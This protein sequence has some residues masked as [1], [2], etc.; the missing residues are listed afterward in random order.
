MAP[1]KHRQ[2]ENMNLVS[3]LLNTNLDRMSSSNGAG[4]AGSSSVRYS[5]TSVEFSKVLHSKIS[6]D[7]V[8]RTSEFQLDVRQV[9]MSAR[10]T[11][12]APRATELRDRSQTRDS[13]SSGQSDSSKQSFQAMF[14]QPGNQELLRQAQPTESERS[15]Q[16]NNGNSSNNGSGSSDTSAA[17]KEVL[18]DQY[19]ADQGESVEESLS[20]SDREIIRKV[21][22]GNFELSSEKDVKE[23]KKL[24]EKLSEK[25]TG[26]AKEK[27]IKLL[28]KLLG[29]NG[30]LQ[31]LIEKDQSAGET[32]KELT[33]LQEILKKSQDLFK[34]LSEQVNQSVVDQLKQGFEKLKDGD[35][36]DSKLNK[37][38]KQIKQ[39]LSKESENQSSVFQKTLKE[40]TKQVQSLIEQFRKQSGEA[41]SKKQSES[42]KS[43]VEQLNKSFGKLTGSGE[44]G[45]SV[46]SET[47]KQYQQA[48]KVA[49]NQLKNSSLKENLAKHLREFRQQNRSD[50]AKQ[51]A[52]AKDESGSTEKNSSKNSQSKNSDGKTN[53]S[54]SQPSQSSSGN[55][56]EKQQ[57]ASESGK[58]TSKQSSQGTEGRT[59]NSSQKAKSQS[60][61]TQSA[62]EAASEKSGSAESS[63]NKYD[64]SKKS[65][66]TSTKGEDAEKSRSKEQTVKA[67]TKS[68]AANKQD[69]ES[70]E[71]KSSENKSSDEKSKTQKS[72]STSTAGQS[73]DR[74]STGG[75]KKSRMA[76]TPQE[77]LKAEQVNRNRSGGGQTV[78]PQPSTQPDQVQQ[79]TRDFREA[80][81]EQVVDKS[82]KASEASK[83]VSE[84][85]AEKSGKEN[86]SSQKHVGKMAQYES[87][88]AKSVSSTDGSGA[89]FSNNGNQQQA[90]QG[91]ASVR[92]S[93][94]RGS[95]F[96][97][98]MR[99]ARKVIKQMV[100]KAQTM[101]ED[102]KQTMKLQLQPPELG[103][104]RMSI[105]L[106]GDRAKAKVHVE[107]G[108]VKNLLDD[109]MAQL[110][111]TMQGI[112]VDLDE[113]DIS[114]YENEGGPQSDSDF[115]FDDEER[116][117]VESA[118]EEAEEPT[119][120]TRGH[121]MPTR[122][123]SSIE[124]VA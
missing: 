57:K 83:N 35:A 117:Q 10:E 67:D 71:A 72:K 96:S 79:Q 118:E 88:A 73:N 77:T 91:K 53:T 87:N 43:L 63:E 97:E 5:S 121:T 85:A 36:D 32:V 116:G 102:G 22:Q 100:E 80:L 56:S 98:R 1:N 45:T 93:S 89:E 28:Q 114:E 54:S 40:L 105:S 111:Q 33:N 103:E 34:S 29:G 81:S 101:M 51:V 42:L 95:D 38:L 18:R 106:E 20:E 115:W 52:S 61:E 58:S 14:N 26:A 62:K 7:G 86:Q 70:K 15:G 25:E 24:L 60:G 48:I 99:E 8:T 55:G 2:V 49:E 21:K 44:K 46:S 50:A 11:K 104:M 120:P 107:K 4:Y 64:E 66:S 123:Y 30:A 37:L 23:F 90:N 75:P 9:E 78:Q 16:S 65:S 39:A 59:S 3:M 19:G 119:A 92:A 41:D 94:P 110:K 84:V 47:V 27:G 6:G 13:G 108:A 17:V 69:N 124:L 109:N 31:Q 68:V 12:K 112:G 122:T 76:R 82:S 113:V 74:E